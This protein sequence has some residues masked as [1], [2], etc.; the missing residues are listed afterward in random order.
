[1]REN[2]QFIPV[3]YCTLPGLRGTGG[4]TTAKIKG[5]RSRGGGREKSERGEF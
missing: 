2:D 3:V 4:G 1:M 5:G